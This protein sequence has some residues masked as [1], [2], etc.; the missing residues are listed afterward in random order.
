MRT[1]VTKRVV[2]RPAV[3]ALL[4]ALAFV[5]VLYAVEFA[6]VLLPAQLDRGGIVSREWSGLDGV[7]WAPLLHADWAHLAANT[8]PVLLFAFLTM[9]GGFGRWVAVTATVWLLG[10]LGVWLFGPSG[11]FTVG[12]SGLAFGWLTYL[13]VRGLFTR[14][15]GQLVLAAVLVFLYGG[16]LWGVLPGVPGVSWQG[17]LSGAVAGVLAAWLTARADTGAPGRPPSVR[18]RGGSLAG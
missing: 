6:D 11:A 13:L 5:A 2:P 3:G 17:H 4:L 14:S 12:A 8:G 16:M 10:G 9:A 15:V 1:P 7:L 18:R